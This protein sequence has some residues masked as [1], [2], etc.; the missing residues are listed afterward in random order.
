[1]ARM[2][3]L[4]PVT[5]EHACGVDYELKATTNKTESDKF[6]NIIRVRVISSRDH[7]IE[8]T[9]TSHYNSDYII[10][11]SVQMKLLLFA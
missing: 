7:T 8:L 1:M 3:Q 5:A 10:K 9:P 4:M 6:V 11:S 2:L